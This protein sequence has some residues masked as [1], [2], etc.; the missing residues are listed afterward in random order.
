[1]NGPAVALKRLGYSKKEVANMHGC[2]ERTVDYLIE[3]GELRAVRLGRKVIIRA[4]DAER[5]LDRD[6]E[7]GNH[8][9]KE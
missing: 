6:R 8:P 5:L 9:S 7:T 4:R 3:R 1:M 2:S